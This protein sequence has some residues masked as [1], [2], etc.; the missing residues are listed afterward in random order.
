[1]TVEGGDADYARAEE[2]TQYDDVT[3]IPSREIP[4]IR[5]ILSRL[6]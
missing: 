6:L 2:Y 3:E 1:V 5:T 4:L